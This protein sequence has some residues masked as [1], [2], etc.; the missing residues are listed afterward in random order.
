MS[1]SVNKVML[2]GKLG[3]DAELSYTS[4]QRAVAKF[5]VA[6]ERRW[7]DQASG[8]WKSETNWTNVIFWNAENMAQFLTKGKQV[9]VEG[10]LQTDEYTDKDGVKRK[11][12]KVRCER[13]VLLGG[14]GGGGRSG[15]GGGYDRGEGR[16]SGGGASSSSHDDVSE[17]LTDDDIP[18]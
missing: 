1:R 6:T 17:P 4:N 12:T 11:S 15:G 7:K 2:V 14:G 10:R 5:S 13:V 9:Y 16:S 8:E 18:F 3:R